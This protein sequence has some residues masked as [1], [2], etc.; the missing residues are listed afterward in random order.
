MDK[1]RSNIKISRVGKSK[2]MKCGEIA[3]IIDYKNAHNIIIKFD[4][5]GE[6]IKCEYGDF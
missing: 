1:I 4:K 2:K 3:T 5:T 6:I